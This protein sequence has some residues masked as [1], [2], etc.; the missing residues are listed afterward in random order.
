M[1]EN[2]RMKHKGFFKFCS[3]GIEVKGIL[4]TE[5]SFKNSKYG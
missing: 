1:E 5:M 3:F 2:S 4:V